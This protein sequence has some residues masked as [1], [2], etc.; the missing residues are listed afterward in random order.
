MWWVLF[1]T[2][3]DA[4]AMH[5]SD[6]ERDLI[7]SDLEEVLRDTSNPSAKALFDPWAA[8]GAAERLERHYRKSNRLD[9]VHR[10]AQ[11]YGHAFESVAQGAD[12]LL[13]VAWLQPVY[14]KY[15]DL[16][17]S[18][19]AKRVNLLLEEKA[20]AAPNSMKRIEVPIDIDQKQLAQYIERLTDGGLEKAIRRIVIK[21]IPNAKDIH[22]FNER[23]KEE[24]PLSSRIS[25]RLFEGDHVAAIVGSQDDDPNGR[26]IHQIS[27]RI[28]FDAPWLRMAFDRVKE[29]YNPTSEDLATF[30]GGS[31]LVDP[32]RIALL[33]EGI[34]AALADDP[35]KAI[36]ILIPQIEHI[37]RSLAGKM[38][39]PQTT[40]GRVK[41]T[42][43]AKGLGE[44][45]SEAIFR[46]V[47][48][49][50]VRLYLAS[51]LS[52]QR[53]LNLRNRVAHG[54]IGHNQLGPQL[55]DRLLHVLLMLAMIEF[56][57]SDS[58]SEN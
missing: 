42:M 13:A 17:M 52:D 22:A 4:K 46:R 5:L 30:V 49:E 16:G 28:N 41:G 14:E 43:Q 3:Y 20:K 6:E 35:V 19:Q 15:R 8:Q 50:N 34:S 56:K 27:T 36:H 57:E 12:P 51:L 26:L 1:D 44:I 32:S 2:L 9:Q 45:M 58:P 37:V 25:M 29:R 54:L 10:V 23:M 55:S 40:R 7:V 48:D 53:G 39:I 38:G 11:M 31:A 18:D 21:F 47:C 33:K 24:A